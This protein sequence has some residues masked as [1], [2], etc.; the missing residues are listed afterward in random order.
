MQENAGFISKSCDFYPL[1]KEMLAQCHPF[2]CGDKDLDE[3]FLG[4]ADDYGHQL[5]GKSF[6]YRLKA[7]PAEIVCAFTLSTSGLDVRDLPRSRKD[8]V[9]KDIPHAK[10]MS[11]YPAALIGRLGVSINYHGRGIGTELLKRG[12]KPMFINFQ[13][14][15]RYLTV[16]AYNNEGTH[17][18]YV[19]NGFT[20]LFSTVQ[21][22]KDYI[23]MPPEKE[24]KT[25]LMYFDLIRLYQ[26]I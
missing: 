9:T 26:Q 16:D 2:S 4:Q 12:I 20:N 23:G 11:N 13:I 1:S 10:N 25:R 6:C 3:F 5:L 8:K 17:K 7:N 15:C 21:Q 24:L 22:E 19:A 14:G 18:F